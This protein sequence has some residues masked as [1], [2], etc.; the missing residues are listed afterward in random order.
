MA[1]D[2]EI[3]SVIDSLGFG[4]QRTRTLNEVAELIDHEYSGTVPRSLEALQ[5]PWR[6]GPYSARAT[7]MFAFG[8]PLALVDTNFARVV[9]RVFDY[10]MPA[11][12]HK[13]DT[14]YEL[15]D[16]LIPG[17]GGLCRS[18]NLALLD[19]AAA[20]CTPSVPACGDCPLAPGCSYA[21]NSGPDL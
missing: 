13:S 15:L 18:F 2:E 21:Q 6:V 14:L 10:E 8:E 16:A 12:P 7:M 11:Q 3:R 20:I 19:L 1:T 5:R 4:N 17:T 9:E